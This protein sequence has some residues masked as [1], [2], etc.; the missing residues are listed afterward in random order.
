[1]GDLRE[2]WEA[3]ESWVTSLQDFPYGLGGVGGECFRRNS[4]SEGSAARVKGQALCVQ[5]IVQ[6]GKEWWVSICECRK[7]GG[8][9]GQ[10]QVAKRYS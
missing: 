9:P 2:S 7:E 5:G 8:S 10:N 3:P 4:T 6:K 1:M